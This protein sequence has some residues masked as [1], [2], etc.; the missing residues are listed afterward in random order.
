MIS[1]EIRVLP[2]ETS[3]Q[4]TEEEFIVSNSD[5]LMIDNLFDKLE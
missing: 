3:E 1:R 5:A 4:S 2:Y